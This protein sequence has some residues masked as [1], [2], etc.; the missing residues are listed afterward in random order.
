MAVYKALSGSPIIPWRIRHAFEQWTESHC[1]DRRPGLY[2]WLHLGE[3]RE[4]LRAVTSGPRHH[5]FGYYEKCPWSASGKLLLAHAATFNDRPPGPDD[6]VTVGVVHLDGDNRYQSLADS[7]AWNWQQGSMLQWHPADPERLLL[8]ND[9][10]NGRFVGVVR[11][12]NGSEVCEY[13][14][15]IYA[16]TP[17]GRSAFS[18]DFARLHAYRPGYGYAGGS[19]PFAAEPHP[20]NDGIHRI[21]LA[22]GRTDLFVSLAQLAH[23]DVNASTRGAFQ[24]INHIQVAP[25][26]RRLAFF[27]IAQT[28]G[29]WRARL[30]V[31]EMDGTGLQCLLDAD[32]VSHYDWLDDDRILIWARDGQR[33]HFWL[34]D[35]TSP[36]R[37]VVGNRVLVE[38]GHV[39]FSPNR[40]WVLNDTYPDRHDM[41]TLMLYRW[42]DARRI[43]LARLHSPKARWWGEIRCDLHPRWSRDGKQVCVDSVHSGQ[44]QMYVM[45]VAEFLE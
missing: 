7:R 26:G 39:T 33:G 29:G 44:R 19:D 2:R 9:R 20:D 30:F 34:V 40:R 3:A 31:C 45:D 5:F 42:S 24:W 21:D 41:R 17:D 4:R 8:H 11:D 18:I 38:D 16:V 12:V 23:L 27:H 13:A 35:R 43:D 22:S 1:R 14:R 32:M 28:P 6:S 25:G 15:P 36:E 37:S 10:R